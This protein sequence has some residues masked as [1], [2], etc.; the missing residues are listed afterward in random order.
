[1]NQATSHSNTTEIVEKNVTIDQTVLD[2]AMSWPEYRDRVSELFDAGAVTGGEATEAMLHYTRLNIARMKRI[3][4]TTV[5]LPETIEAL[6]ATA[7]RHEWVVLTEGWCGD[8]AQIVPV[9]GLMAAA[10]PGTELRII[11]RDQHLDIMDA[12]LTNGGR[13]IPK[14]L[15]VDRNTREVIASWGPRPAVLQEIIMQTR[16]RAEEISDPALYKKIID[17]SKEDAQRWYTSD[18]TVSIQAEVVKLLQSA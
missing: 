12:F 8:A 10:T 13:S 18:K 7:G 9:L 17:Q 2:N 11:L 4:K 1:M 16:E 15:L 5:L 14:L 3:E 6:E